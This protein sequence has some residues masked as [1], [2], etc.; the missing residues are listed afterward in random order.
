M[1]Y[2]KYKEHILGSENE[3]KELEPITEEAAKQN[4][5]TL[6]ILNKLNPRESRRSFCIS[7]TNNIFLKFEGLNLLEKPDNI[8]TIAEDSW[9]SRKIYSGNVISINTEYPNWKEVLDIRPKVKWKINVVGLGDVGSMLIT[10][11]RLLGGTDISTIGIYDLDNN[12]ILRHLY[13]CNQILSPF[14]NE[15]Y[16]EII[17]LK[18]DELFNCDMFV[19]C[20]T[21]GI[22]PLGSEKTDVR[23]AQFD[24]NSKIMSIYSKMARNSNFKGIFAVVSDPV[25]LLCK[26]ALTS[27]NSNEFGVYDYQGLVPE[28]IRGYGLGVMNARATYYARENSKAIHYEKEGRAF[29]PH[30]EGLVIVDS[31]DNYNPALSDYLTAKAQNA[32]LEVRNTGYK[33]YIAPALSSGSLAI[34]DTIR[35]NWHYSSTYMGKVFIGAKNRLTPLGVEIEQVNLPPQVM[36]KL[37]NTYER[38]CEFI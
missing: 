31:I 25:D 11:L 22:P 19:F 1:I 34:I 36:Q 35:G 12:K 14:N 38:L 15:T 28:Q 5:T 6:Y 17:E 2:Y 4:C 23:I 16:P 24:T 21:G 33:P 18:Q 7:N 32:N 3:Y 29:G 37:T 8:S 20:V 30:G 10:G 13:E 27:S 9:I 26:T